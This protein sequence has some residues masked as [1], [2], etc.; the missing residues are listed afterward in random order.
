MVPHG[1]LGA[2]Y[3]ALGQWDK[4]ILATQEAMRLEPNAITAYPNLAGAYVAL[5]RLDDARAVLEQAKAR[6]L[7]SVLLHLMQYDLA[8]LKGDT[9]AMSREVA[10]GSG[11]PGDEDP[12]LSAQSDTEAYYG[13]LGDARDFSRRAVD[14]AKRADSK[15]TAALW[16]VNGA[17][18]EAEFENSA[19]AQHEAEAALTLA[20]GRDV[21]LLAA[22]TEAR[23]GNI[24]TAEKFVQE[25]EKNDPSNTVL[26]VY[27]LPAVK[28][29]IEIARGNSGQALNLLQAS[30]PY[31]MGSPPPFQ[32][33]SLY[34]VYL[35]GEAYLVAR[36]GSAAAF[37]FQKLIDHPGMVLNF[38][39]GA[40]ARVGVAR[41]RVLAGDSAGA[42]KAYQDFFALWKDA[43][44][45][46][47]VLKQAKAEYAKLQ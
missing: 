4:S 5:G 29:A 1:N 20:P 14:S 40:L 27:W 13:R 23:A 12:L 38:P 45:D 10:W 22:L 31:E 34:P 41:A 36:Q 8:F 16:Q 25:L 37:E 19:I 2:N 21:Q 6:N 18:R 24:K 7:E 39:L 15:E 32:T 33:E 35:R 3:A 43:D 46:I 44:L 9:P 47:P 11:K 26:K 28:A 42:K 30:A 17:L